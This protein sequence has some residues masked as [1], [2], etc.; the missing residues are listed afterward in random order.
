[1]YITETQVR[2]RYGESD[3]M[4]YVYYG[5]YP[6]YYEVGRTEMLRTLGLTYKD[7]EDSGI[8]LPVISLQV[9]YLAPAFYDDLLTV[10][11]YLK[12]IP[13]VRIRFDYEV[14]NAAGEKL[15]YGDTTLVFSDAKTRRPCRPPQYFMD[16]I[17]TFFPT[18]TS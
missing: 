15:N 5:N 8:I 2:V 16:Q 18:K 4:G 14:Y 1:M 7:M 6:L 17:A 3:R 13:S 9:H 11:T 12:E 10:K